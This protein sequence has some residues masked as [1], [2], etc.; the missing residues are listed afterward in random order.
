[1]PERIKFHFGQM[2]TARQKTNETQA[3][4][5]MLAA[6][7]STLIGKPGQQVR[8]TNGRDP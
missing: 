1:M 7:I 2:Q 5:I 4:W 8:L 6:F 3:D